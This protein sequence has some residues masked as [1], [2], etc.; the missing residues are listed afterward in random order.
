MG[1]FDPCECLDLDPE[2]L[3][4]KSIRVEDPLI[5][6][7]MIMRYCPLGCQGELSSRGSKV[8]VAIHFRLN[9]DVQDYWIGLIF[10]LWSDTM[11]VVHNIHFCASIRA[12]R[13]SAA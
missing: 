1:N 5:Q 2:V 3:Y 12:S 8:E 13:Y 11:P 7:R 10:V 9:L 6:N 4:E